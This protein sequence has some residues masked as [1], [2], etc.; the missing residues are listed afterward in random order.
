MMVVPFH[1]RSAARNC[2]RP[3]IQL[4][5]LSLPRLATTRRRWRLL[6]LAAERYNHPAALE[7][8]LLELCINNVLKDMHSFLLHVQ[9]GS[10]AQ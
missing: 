8:A 9:A 5:S 7:D 2:R 1:S 10:G 4:N 6:R 3:A